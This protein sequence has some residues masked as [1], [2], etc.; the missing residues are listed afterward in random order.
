M[1]VVIVSGCVGTGK[2]TVAKK[3]SE[4]LD[5]TYL[6]VNKVI[7]DNGLGEE[8]D[9]K[10][11]SKIIDIEDLNNVLISII[12]KKKKGIVIDSHLSHYLPKE[13]V[14]FCIITKCEL[15]ELEVRLNKRK[16]HKEKVRENL[17]AEIFDT[18]RVEALENGHKI[19][20]IHTEKDVKYGELIK[21]IKS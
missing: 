16:Y 17:D 3:L 13:K 6:D 1:K 20:I 19:I 12:D 21:K 14:D 10:R 15:K 18:C 4:V 9:K 8:Y 7:R 5:F 2:T 11:K